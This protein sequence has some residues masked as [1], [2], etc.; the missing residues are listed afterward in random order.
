MKFFFFV[1]LI[2][3]TCK[4]QV[5][6]SEAEDLQKTDPTQFHAIETFAYHKWQLND[7]RRIKE[8]NDQTEAYLKVCKLV[9][10][11]L[12]RHKNC[13]KAIKMYSEESKR[14]DPFLNPTI[15]WKKVLFELQAWIDNKRIH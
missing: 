4:S 5:L 8:I 3:I 2:S 12:R 10:D 14:K 9:T 1:F 15:N 6:T 11:D 7:I 13:M